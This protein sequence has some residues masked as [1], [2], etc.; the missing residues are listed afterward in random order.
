MQLWG[1]AIRTNDRGVANTMIY[2]HKLR[3]KTH[4]GDV[5]SESHFRHFYSSFAVKGI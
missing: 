5:E 1:K 3:T 2:G 4:L